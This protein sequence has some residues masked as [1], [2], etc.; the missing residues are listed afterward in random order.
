MNSS[1]SNDP[2]VAL[3]KTSPKPDTQR[4]L[5]D[6]QRLRQMH[7]RLRR[8]VVASLCAV[9][10][11]LIVA[12]ATGR[13][14]THG[15]FSVIWIFGLAVGAVWQRRARCNRIDAVTSDS[16]SLLKF[17]LARARSDLFIARSLYAGV[18]CG[19]LAGA[20]LTTLI[21]RAASPAKAAIHP[22]LHPI[23]TVAGVAILAT[24]AA[25]GVILARSRHLQ[26]KAL[27][28]K[29]RAAEAGL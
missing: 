6:L 2:L 1:P 17:M 9:S 23:L 21:R 27:T 8:I 19:A 11:L 18:P 28:E 29:L 7:Q 13:I 3:W 5:Q 16:V 4:L 10:L 26:V 25:V 14:A 20:L 15:I 24:M 22:A 12:E